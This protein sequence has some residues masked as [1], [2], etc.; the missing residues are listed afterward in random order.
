MFTTTL[1]HTNRRHA[2]YRLTLHRDGDWWMQWDGSHTYVTEELA[3][4]LGRQHITLAD[5]AA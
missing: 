3:D 2:P 1:T 5:T 4:Y